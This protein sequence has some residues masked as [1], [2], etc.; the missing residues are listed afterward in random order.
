MPATAETTAAAE[1]SE[2]SDRALNAEIG[3]LYTRL[4]ERSPRDAAKLLHAYP[5]EFVEAVLILLN[6][7]S[8]QQVLDALPRPRRELILAAASPENRRQ[9]LANDAYPEHT[10]GRLM[11]PALAI[12]PATDTVAQ[13]T[14]RLRTLTRRAFITYPY[15]VD[16]QER[17][18]G[19]VVMRDMLLGRP[20]QTLGSIMYPSP[21]ALRPE[22]TLLEA[23]R[24]TMLRHFPVYPVVDGEGHIA[25]LVR[26]QMLFEQQAVELSA[27]AGAMVGVQEEERLSTTWRRS[28][29]FRHP[30]LQVNLL[31]TF[32]AA[33]VVG[34][35][36]HTIA[37]T[38][39]LAAF[40]P[41]MISQCANVGCQ[42]LAVSLRGLTL[43]E[44]VPGRARLLAFKESW[45]GLLNGFLT[46]L[47]AGVGMYVSARWSG[48]A[49]PFMLAVVVVGALTVSC[50]VA[51]LVGALTPIGLK[52]CGF[53]PATASSI[54][55]TTITD[56]V[57][58]AAL[59]ALAAWLVVGRS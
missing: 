4:V 39:V 2:V 32:L 54:V 21:F 48:H 8:R 31:T 56:L 10:V 12:F 20:E 51:G 38:A 25:G 42:A 37:S 30:W 16:A 36:E 49:H 26:G 28:L 44:L 9:W 14:E 11:E 58:V 50:V 19:V 57:S 34:G 33:A 17:L 41:V 7:A 43:G 6:P 29:R 24:E 47:T 55:L 46:G 45:L 22:Q 18:V 1:S 5:D 59:L 15:V 52:R 3:Q 40:V 35:F 27:Q 13:A 23:M 53:D